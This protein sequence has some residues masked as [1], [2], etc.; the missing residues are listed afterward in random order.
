MAAYIETMS[1]LPVFCYTIDKEAFVLPCYS[2]ECGSGGTS[3]EDEQVHNNKE[4]IQ[5]QV[6][7]ALYAKV[8]KHQTSFHTVLF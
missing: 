7:K 4:I 1:L 6:G 5:T 2:W 8:L 3:V